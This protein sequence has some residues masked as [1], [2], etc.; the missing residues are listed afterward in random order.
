MRLVRVEVEGYRSIAKKIELHVDRDVTVLLGAN[1]HGKTNILSALGH[2]N[3]D[4]PFVSERDLN[5][6]YAAKPEG[7]PSVI[8]HFELDA[9]ERDE[10]LQLANEELEDEY[11]AES[12]ATPGAGT[13]QD[14]E[15][16]P[17]PHLERHHIPPVMRVERVGVAGKLQYFIDGVS[18]TVAESF[19]KDA[20]PRV[21][22]IRP[23]EKVPDAVNSAQLN[24]ESHE[25]MRGIFYYAGIQP[26]GP[27]DMF[28]QTD[29]TMMR[30]K[31]ASAK[32]NETLKLTGSRA[33]IFATN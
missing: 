22:L 25:F 15:D 33:R 7:F 13:E 14:A 19:G 23:Q 8:F 5:W 6:D 29:A 10:L 32:L 20:A 27:A 30:L 17:V 1:D 16:L 21:E 31:Q 12:P 24:S 28:S 26:D 9:A 4:E 2:L 11:S 3:E 18:D